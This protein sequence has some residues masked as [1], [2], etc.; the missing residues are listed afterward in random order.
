MKEISNRSG[1]I[2]VEAMIRLTI[3]GIVVAAAL[4]YIARLRE[5]HPSVALILTVIA[6][7]ALG[8]ATVFAAI[9]R[10]MYYSWKHAL[11]IPI[12]VILLFSVM[13]FMLWQKDPGEYKAENREL[14][15]TD[16]SAP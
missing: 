11:T 13:A 4:P 1:F 14:R 15:A 5:S 7:G 10:K 2:H 3:V 9:E 16:E 6:C 12:F 8:V